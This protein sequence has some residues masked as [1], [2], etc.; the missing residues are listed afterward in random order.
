VTS[1]GAY[2]FTF[3]FSMT[4]RYVFDDK[5]KWRIDLKTDESSMLSVYP[6]SN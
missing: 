6:V 1:D 5:T 3:A 4:N 2:G